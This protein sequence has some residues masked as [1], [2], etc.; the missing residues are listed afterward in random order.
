MYGPSS[1]VW[2][3]PPMYG[4]SSDVWTTPPMYGRYLRHQ[5][6]RYPPMGAN[7]GVFQVADAPTYGYIYRLPLEGKAARICNYNVFLK[8]K[9]EKM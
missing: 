6:P 5:L 8:F 9:I 4:A 1:D 3:I 2:T 7:V